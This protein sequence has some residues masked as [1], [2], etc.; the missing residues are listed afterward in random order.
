VVDAGKRGVHDLRGH[1]VGEHFL[2]PHVGKPPHR[3]QI[4]EPHMGRL[5]CDRA[6]AIELLVLRRRFF[7]QQ[8]RR[9]VEDRTRA[10][11]QGALDA[12]RLARNA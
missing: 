12:L 11:A 4:A 5:V 10:Q 3:H 6:G 2:H 1:E 9:V 7:E 8:A